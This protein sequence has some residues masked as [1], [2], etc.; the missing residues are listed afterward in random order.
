MKTLKIGDE[1]ELLNVINGMWEHFII[2]SE[3]DLEMIKEDY[4]GKV[5][6]YEKERV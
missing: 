2:I 3:A 4:K 1:V 6:V 5:R